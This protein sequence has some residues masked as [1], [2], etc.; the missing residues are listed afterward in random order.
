[1]ESSILNIATLACSLMSALGLS[2]SFLNKDAFSLSNCLHKS[3][4]QAWNACVLNKLIYL[5]GS[6]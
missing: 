3:V 6:L 2:Q 4:L 1:M 5:F